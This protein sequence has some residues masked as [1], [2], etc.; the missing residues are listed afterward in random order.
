MFVTLNQ[1][2]D[3]AKANKQEADKKVAALQEKLANLQASADKSDADVEVA[4]QLLIK[5]HVELDAFNKKEEVKD[6][7]T[8][9][10]TSAKSTARK[11]QA[12]TPATG[13]VSGIGAVVSSVLGMSFLATAAKRKKNK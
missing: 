6:E 4:R 13:D 5:R 7:M 10:E 2:L 11:K 8:A 9:A 3:T 12:V 1:N